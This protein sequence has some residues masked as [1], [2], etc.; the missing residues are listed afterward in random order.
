M[1]TPGGYWIFGTEPAAADHTDQ[2]TIAAAPGARFALASDGFLRLIEVFGVAN[3]RDFL[4]I[5]SSERFSEEL[6]RLRALECAPRTLADY[7]RI[8]AHDD[9]AFVQCEYRQED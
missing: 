9:V 6:E 8:K 7:P 2:I 3:A 5:D 1:N 4:A